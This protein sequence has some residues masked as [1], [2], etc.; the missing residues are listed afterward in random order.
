MLAHSAAKLGWKAPQVA[1]GAGSLLSY[2]CGHFIAGSGLKN[3]QG[4]DTDCKLLIIG[5][6]RTT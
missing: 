5:T 2:T 6:P 4:S 1:F 3:P